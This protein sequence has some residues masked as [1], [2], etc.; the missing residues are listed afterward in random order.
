MVRILKADLDGLAEAAAV[1]AK[2]G[3][4]AY[5]T[6]TVYGLGCDPLNSSADENVMNAKGGRKKAVPILVKS[7]EDAD[8]VAHI[9]EQARRL[10][11][12]F[13]PGPLT[14]V[15]AARNVLPPILVPDGTV[16]LRSP[17]HAICLKLL[18]LCSGLL[19]GTSANLTGKPPATAAEEVVKAFGDQI[20]IVLDGGKSPLGVASTVVDLTK[21][22]IRVLREG[23]IGRQEILRRLRA[24]RPR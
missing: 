17:D 14:I 4:I 7:L 21:N 23:P 24:R 3:L 6:D 16:G 2:G 15:L 8:K 11:Q 1:V 20:D 5:P 10:A 19:V 13:W 9:S 12:R 18:E 22:R